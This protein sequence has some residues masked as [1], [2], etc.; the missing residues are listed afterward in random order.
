VFFHERRKL[1]DGVE[2]SGGTRGRYGQ[3]VS[4]SV[5]R[6]RNGLLSGNADNGC[7]VEYLRYR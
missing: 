6:G 5:A 2:V 3:H 4:L 7:N 1:L